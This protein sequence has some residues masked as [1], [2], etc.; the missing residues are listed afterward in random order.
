[1]TLR[2]AVRFGDFSKNISKPLDRKAKS[3]VI[4]ADCLKRKAMRCVSLTLSI[5]TAAIVTIPLFICE[6]ITMC[7]GL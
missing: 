1:M 7:K 4:L 5:C 6:M 3:S 2:T